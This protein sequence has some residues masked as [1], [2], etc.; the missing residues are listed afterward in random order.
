[1]VRTVR[2]SF[3]RTKC[4]NGYNY[5]DQTFDYCTFKIDGDAILNDMI[6]SD[7]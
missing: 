5:I 6:D 3:V 2:S 1:M 4:R 7:T